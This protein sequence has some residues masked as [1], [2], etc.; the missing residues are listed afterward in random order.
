METADTAAAA[1]T[2]SWPSAEG[3][4]SLDNSLPRPSE[5]EVPDFG[6][7]KPCALEVI[8]G[9][10]GCQRCQALPLPITD[11]IGVLWLCFPQPQTISKALRFLV[12]FGYHCEEQDN[13]LRI[14]SRQAKSFRFCRHSLT[15]CRP[16]SSRRR[17]RFFSPKG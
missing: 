9:A 15:L 12:D 3:I 6:H 16:P 13:S 10:P 8:T 14:R 4:R 5:K 17:G 11:Q 2:A 7:R 1:D